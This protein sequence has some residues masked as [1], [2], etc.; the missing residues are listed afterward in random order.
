M[1]NRRMIIV[2]GASS[3]I[4]EACLRA[5]ADE[6]GADFHL[7]GRDE[8]VLDAIA[9]DLGVRDPETR[10]G[11]SVL[12]FQEPEAIRTFSGLT[13]TQHVDTV[14]IAHG[15]LPVQSEMQDDLQALSDSLMLNAISPALFAEAFAARLEHQGYGTLAVIGSVAG[16]RGRKSNYAYGAAKGLL[17]R[18]VEGLQHRF[19]SDGPRAIL[20]KPGPTRTRMTAQMDQSGMA[21][22]DAVASDILRGIKA[23]KPVIYTPGKWRVIMAVIRLLPRAIFNR[24]DI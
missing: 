8:E 11:R 21:D 3:G 5:W 23:G 20:I 13:E 12:D 16:D 10:V 17:E 9:D 7:L 6:G 24:L 22:P 19:G 14:L 15:A 18:Y 4:A 2:V 1:S